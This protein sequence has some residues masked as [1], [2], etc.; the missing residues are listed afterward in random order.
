[1][2]LR[3]NVH[4]DDKRAFGSANFGEMIGKIMGFV[5]GMQFLTWFVGI[6]TLIAGVIAIGSILLITVKERT[7]EIGIRR[8]IGATP[9]KIRSQ[10]VLESVFLTTI[11]GALGIIFAG[12]VLMLI[13]MFLADKDGFPFTNPTVNIP[14]ALGAVFA[15]VFFGSLIG[16]IPA[17]RAVSI[18]P[19]E[20]LREE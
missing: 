13:N 10:I 19:I 11:A 9:G 20:A 2:K 5:K 4:P 14:I 8:A 15:L 3:H 6:S 1:L 16:M 7:R 17:Q 12:G 18:R